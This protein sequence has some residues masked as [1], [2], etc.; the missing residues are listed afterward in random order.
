[1]IAGDHGKA[2]RAAQAHPGR[3]FRLFTR[4]P[5]QKGQGMREISGGLVIMAAAIV[6][7]ASMVSHAIRRPGDV[8]TLAHV[9]FLI[10][11]FLA[12]FGGFLILSAPLT[13]AAR[14]TTGRRG[15]EKPDAN[16]PRANS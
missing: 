1:M 7:A 2:L 4:H 10:A 13:D 16:N 12:I 14:T 5:K 15:I 3:A 6:F 11:G 8:D 9:G